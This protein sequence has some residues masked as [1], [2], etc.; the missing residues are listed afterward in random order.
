MCAFVCG[1]VYLCLCVC[2]VCMHACISAWRQVIIL[3]HHL[4]RS[5]LHSLR[6]TLL[7]LEAC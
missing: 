3:R 7:E 1:W 6:Q 4:L 2:M 5:H